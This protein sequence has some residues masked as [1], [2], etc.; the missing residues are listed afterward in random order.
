[1]LSALLGVT[2][3]LC[4]GAAL[5]SAVMPLSAFAETFTTINN[6]AD[7]LLQ[8][9]TFNQLLGIND[10]GVIAGYYGDGVTVNNHG[11]VYSSGT[12]TAE[13]SPGT[14][15]ITAD[16]TQ[17]VALN[18]VQSGG[19]YETAG[20]WANNASMTN[21]GFTKVGGTFTNVTGPGGATV[22]QVLGLND[23]G[24]AVGFYTN[25][26]TTSGFLYTLSSNTLTTIA[27]PSAWNATA[28]TAAG[29]NNAGTI[30]GFYTSASGTAGF[31]DKGGTFTSPTDPFGMNPMFFGINNL[32]DIVGD[33]T[34]A[35]GATEGFV[36]DMNTNTW[37]LVT[38][39]NASQTADGF[40][41][42]GTT[43]N[44][45]NDQGFVVG[46]YADASG[47]VDGLLVNTAPE[48]ATVG[49]LGLAGLLG[50]GAWTRRRRGQR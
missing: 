44:G 35:D 2:R 27:T 11:F 45:I 21:Y 24:Q 13:N 25:S 49:L 32:G 9:P 3:K 5:F 15:T 17:V 6:P 4:F 8:T 36:Y 33:D 40:G 43:L 7:N 34:A 46:F 10:A 39:P 50:L 42:S 26:T 31:I 14:S 20:F 37:T 41:I 23:H 22:T 1:M 28:V 18:N 29:I 47:N 30:V 12:F 19:S 48:P 16:Q 38:D